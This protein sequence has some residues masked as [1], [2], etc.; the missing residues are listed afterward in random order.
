MSTNRFVLNIN[1][2]TLDNVGNSLI[3]S[4]EV[5]SVHFYDATSE[6]WAKNFSGVQDV[7]NSNFDSTASGT[8]PGWN[9]TSSTSV[10]G[11][12]S[13]VPNLSL[14][15]ESSDLVKSTSTSASESSYYDTSHKA[16]R[17]TKWPM[18]TS[19]S[20]YT[21]KPWATST[22]SGTATFDFGTIKTFDTLYMEWSGMKGS[23]L[24]GDPNTTF[25]RGYHF[26]SS[27]N[28][29]YYTVVASGT[30]TSGQ[31][32]PVV[33]ELQNSVAARYLRVHLDTNWGGSRTGLSELGAYERP[34]NPVIMMWNNEFSG[35]STSDY[36][37]LS[38]SI[39]MTGHSKLF[40]DIGAHT[41]G[42]PSSTQYYLKVYI[43]TDLVFDSSSPQKSY[44]SLTGWAKFGYL[45]DIS[46]YSGSHTVK[47]RFRSASSGADHGRHLA[48]AW[49]GRCSFMPTWW[50][51]SPSSKRGYK[52][53]FP[54]KSIIVS[55]TLGLSI[56]DASIVDEYG[57]VV[58]YLWMR[59]DYLKDFIKVPVEKISA[60][61][62]K[63]YL[64]TGSGL[65]ILDFVND[66][67]DRYDSTGQYRISGIVRRNQDTLYS[68]T[69]PTRF[70]IDGTWE[71]VSTDSSVKLQNGYVLSLQA[72][73]ASLGEYV[74][75]GTLGGAFALVSGTVYKSTFINPVR[76]VKVLNDSAV[77]LGY[78][79]GN[80]SRLGIINDISSVGLASFDVDEVIH[81]HA[82]GFSESFN[83]GYNEDNWVASGGEFFR[84]TASGTY[85]TISG[86]VPTL[87]GDGQNAYLLVKDMVANRPFKATA[88]VKLMQ[89][90]DLCPGELRFGAFNSEICG[91]VTDYV[92]DSRGVYL[93]AR[94]NHSAPLYS[95]DFGDGQ[96]HRQNFS[97]DEPI[98]NDTTDEKRTIDNALLCAG[99]GGDV[100]E[101]SSS[102]PISAYDFILKFKVRAYYATANS[103]FE[104]GLSNE[105]TR[106]QGAGG[107]ILCFRFLRDGSY[108]SGAWNI[109]SNNSGAYQYGSYIAFT[110]SDNSEG[111]S[112]YRDVVMHYY[113]SSK[114]ISV[115]ID[116][117]F[118]GS[119]SV[120]SF[121]QEAYFYV[122]GT[123]SGGGKFIATVKDMTIDYYG[124]QTGSV[125]KRYAV[126]KKSGTA[127]DVYGFD[128]LWGSS[129]SPY[130]LSSYTAFSGTE[131]TPSEPWRKWEIYY[132]PEHSSLAG[133]IDNCYIGSV[134]LPYSDGN[135]RNISL[136]F[137]AQFYPPTTASGN[138]FF[139]VG[140]K[141]FSV[142]YSGSSLRG[143]PGYL[144]P[145]SPMMPGSLN[146]FDG[147]LEL[148]EDLASPQYDI[149]NINV[150]TGSDEGA[151][152][153]SIP[154]QVFNVVSGTVQN[155]DFKVASIPSGWTTKDYSGATGTS[156]WTVAS[157]ILKQ[158]G[159][160][161]GFGGTSPDANYRG[162]FGSHLLT[163]ISTDR[164]TTDSSKMVG[165]AIVCKLKTTTSGGAG[166]AFNA[167]YSTVGTV[168]SSTGYY[169]TMYPDN[170][171]VG[172]FMTVYDSSIPSYYSQY[173][174][175]GSVNDDYSRIGVFRDIGLLFSST[176]KVEIYID[177]SKKLEVNDSPSDNLRG[178]YL[179][180][181]SN[182]NTSLEVEGVHV[183][184]RE[185]VATVPTKVTYSS[186]YGGGDNKTVFGNQDR[187]L[188]VTA[189]SNFDKVGGLIEVGTSTTGY[190]KWGS[191]E[192]IP[193]LPYSYGTG[194]P[195]VYFS[196]EELRDKLIATICKVPL[197]QTSV[198]ARGINVLKYDFISGKWRNACILNNAFS[199][200]KYDGSSIIESDGYFD[201]GSVPNN[202]YIVPVVRV[203]NSNS[204]LFFL[205]YFN[206][207]IY[208]MTTGKFGQWS[209][210]EVTGEK[211]VVYSPKTYASR[212]DGFSQ[213]RG[214]GSTSS[215]S[216]FGTPTY[217]WYDGLV[218]LTRQ[219][220]SGQ[221]AVQGT[222]FWNIFPSKGGNWSWSAIGAQSYDGV[223][224][225]IPEATFPADPC[226]VYCDLNDS[227]YVI[228]GNKFYRVGL[229]RQAIFSAA[230]PPFTTPNTA[231]GTSIAYIPK[232]R[233]IYV[234]SGS[235]GVIFVYN[236]MTDQWDNT[237]S[238]PGGTAAGANI[239]YS[240]EKDK[241]FVNNGIDSQ[242]Y[243]LSTP[244]S[245]DTIKYDTIVEAGVLPEDS[246]YGRF[247]WNGPDKFIKDEPFAYNSMDRST[248]FTTFSGGGYPS[249]FDFNAGY[250]GSSPDGAAT[251]VWTNYW[252]GLNIP[253][254]GG[255]SS[256]VPIRPQTFTA[257]VSTKV[258]KIPVTN[259]S[260]NERHIVFGVGEGAI[261][262]GRDL[263][264]NVPARLHRMKGTH[265][266]YLTAINTPTKTNRY[267]L[268][269]SDGS[270]ASSLASSTYLAFDGSE[271]SYDSPFRTWRI[272]FDSTTKTL[273]GYVDDTLVGSYSLSSPFLNMFME[274]GIYLPPPLNS[275]EKERSVEFKN[276]EV[277]FNN[278]YPILTTES[279]TNRLVIN[280]AVAENTGFYFDRTVSSLDRTMDFVY[281][282]KLEISTYT[283]TAT[284]YITTIGRLRDGN[285]EINL[286]ALKTAS[287]KSIGFW[288]GKDPWTLA[289]GYENVVAVDWDN[290]TTYKIVKDS[291][292]VNVYLDGSL[293]PAISKPYEEFPPVLETYHRNVAFGT[294]D[295]NSDRVEIVD[296][297]LDEYPG[298]KITRHSSWTRS[299][300]NTDNP[301]A[302]PSWYGSTVS[303]SRSPGNVTDNLVWSFS[304]T[305]SGTKHLYAANS[306]SSTSAATDIP[307]TVY[308]SGTVGLPTA[309]G[310]ATTNISSVSDN[311][312]HSGTY[313]TGATTVYMDG[314]RFHSGMMNAVSSNA[315]FQGL[316][317]LGK[318]Y[319]PTSVV[320]TPNASGGTTIYPGT[321]FLYDFDPEARL[322]STSTT[323][324]TYVKLEIGATSFTEATDKVSG[325]SIIDT[326]FGDLIDYYGQETSP[327]ISGSDVK[328]IDIA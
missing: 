243:T 100:K 324:W 77:L 146:S 187:T 136:G 167:S 194:N 307:F 16:D 183:Y 5:L 1:S 62:G 58:P 14:L 173:N 17:L 169:L 19:T 284:P 120:P 97:F 4:N 27:T 148:S 252:A 280:K 180:I 113:A 87:H 281:E 88:Y 37:E 15:S 112:A 32:F 292:T 155:F 254:I 103:Y 314:Q 162:P 261:N 28:G 12:Y 328:T 225:Y 121:S 127:K 79:D 60:K 158:S 206:C 7:S 192:P 221:S 92:S 35:S 177:G 51:E 55:D 189:D 71:T 199:T 90:P 46:A 265:G 182:N 94:N 34:T 163:N 216:C 101:F 258:A 106:T 188:A 228:N 249:A 29:S 257:S 141:D 154:K 266:V 264:T 11:S 66:R 52:K 165:N 319:N 117:Q 13:V 143:L 272:G 208:D 144:K 68:N 142:T 214:H 320:V 150:V 294:I 2:S 151:S 289:S 85:A 93:S 290:D 271:G 171:S 108:P 53:A 240:H 107:Q 250:V 209:S 267:S 33:L 63:I 138:K 23:S 73:I 69:S 220:Y 43:D 197:T 282:T 309:D 304:S 287:N 152:K 140:I 129:L 326:E 237:I 298:G 235:E 76:N 50:D 327:P 3:G 300:H 279:G 114:S 233:R 41:D 161:R 137:N 176:S 262:T 303:R 166:V 179:S 231:R 283:N 318:Y 72:G 219:L 133:Y 273:T 116:G 26:E 54:D 242:V 130:V 157:G 193:N 124:I 245:I 38:Q 78:S 285:K 89:W 6:S 80:S 48:Y 111:S 275:N 122:F 139:E 40:V 123:S 57:L 42:A 251:R 321:M 30:T 82:D 210:S 84:V 49:V 306:Y 9:D 196:Y 312:T 83:G 296:A 299:G 317:Y 81:Q 260:G 131:G 207:A 212:P 159:N 156:S 59:F 44:G 302:G 132:S 119:V 10:V 293:T 276:L 147:K 218:Y 323:K 96:R 164:T 64:A 134:N 8:L 255:I 18:S 227:I 25:P 184:R 305:S 56:L 277:D 61:N 102:S 65:Y 174:V 297:S 248:W 229:R 268:V 115:T 239:F 202:I 247:A 128:Y 301:D 67:L 286:C 39:D 325:F 291:S 236:V 191:I 104:V 126:C 98:F 160:I 259:N 91:H 22:N 185:K 203:P 135:I 149:T 110:G 211:H 99:I 24:S 195:Y 274:L 86:T 31:V 175:L 316:C 70:K 21:S 230:A 47:F 244:I 178:G 238:V 232:M 170:V 217:S 186:S 313:Q 224:T 241:L 234:T 278:S 204:I 270:S 269:K 125:S 145:F 181:I 45:L 109:Y 253:Y 315:H 201:Y 190:Y 95:D 36:A 256:R 311:T 322:K 172:S 200:S 213:W 74:V 205:T 75:G 118:L 246:T 222:H 263:G 215:V 226:F 105:A 295:L 288:N 308:H 198:S 168:V 20:Y 153:F 223:T 310:F